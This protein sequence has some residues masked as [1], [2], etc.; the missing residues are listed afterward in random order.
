[1]MQNW[2]SIP[3]FILSW[4]TASIRLLATQQTIYCV[5]T[6]R[7]Y[8]VT[9]SAGVVSWGS[10]CA[11]EKKPG[12]YARLSAVINWIQKASNELRGIHIEFQDL[13]DLSTL[14]A[15]NPIKY[16][17]E[18]SPYCNN[19][20]LKVGSQVKGTCSYRKCKF[21]CENNLNQV[22]LSSAKCKSS[23]WRTKDKILEVKCNRKCLHT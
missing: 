18:S 21:S 19:E 8:N 6:W 16:D 17:I 3:P 7:Y 14:Q 1:M 22:S 23:G 20:K 10:G 11:R 2:L 5:K 9:F 12:V 4:N 15:H 13:K